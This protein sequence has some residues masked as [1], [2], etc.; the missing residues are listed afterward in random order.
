MAATNGTPSAFTIMAIPHHLRNLIQQT[1]RLRTKK[2]SI[3]INRMNAT[4][5]DIDSTFIML[6]L[7]YM[8]YASRY[9]DSIR[10]CLLPLIENVM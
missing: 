1:L 10:G 9:R 7:Y 3:G 8:E 4:H 6:I 2:R 5:E